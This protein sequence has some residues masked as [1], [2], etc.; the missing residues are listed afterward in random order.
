MQETLNLSLLPT[1]QVFQVMATN[2]LVLMLKHSEEIIIHFSEEISDEQYSK[3]YRYELNLLS[4][5]ILG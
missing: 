3:S 1:L 2:L 5:G 4:S